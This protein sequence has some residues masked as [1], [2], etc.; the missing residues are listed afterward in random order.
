MEVKAESKKWIKTLIL[1]PNSELYLCKNI[2]KIQKELKRY[3][4]TVSK[5]DIRGFISSQRSFGQLTSNYSRHR[6]G[7][8]GKSF[9]APAVYFK[10]CHSDIC[11]LSRK[12]NYNTRKTLILSFIDGLSGYAL[13]ENVASTSAKHIVPA[14]NALFN[15]CKWLPADRK[16]LIVDAGVEYTSNEMKKWCI[17]NNVKLNVIRHR[18]IRGS[19]GSGIA[20]NLNRRLR[21]V[22]ESLMVETNVPKSFDDKIK[23]A[24][25]ML[26]NEKRS[27]LDNMSA[28]EVLLTQDARYIVNLKR[29][30][31]FRRQKWLR[32]ERV[33]GQTIKLWAIVRIK[34]YSDKKVF[35]KKES[36]GLVSKNMYIV[37]GYEK[38]DSVYYYRLGNLW[39]LKP[40][41]NCTYSSAELNT[42]DLSYEMACYEESLIGLTFV[43]KINRYSEYFNDYA[44]CMFIGHD[45]I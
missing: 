45:L 35:S 21:R 28:R 10:V 41:A 9:D 2:S 26:N 36:Y 44:Q 7:Q 25:K 23:L 19:K 15:R 8:V 43:K 14:F 11:V 16:T 6:I 1:D 5:E 17:D 33:K 24:E 12:R 30:M 22:L 3:G 32:I 4:K 37:I 29:S 18:A 31:K 40:I 20:E 38:R 34:V 39:S 42:T 27:S 13:I